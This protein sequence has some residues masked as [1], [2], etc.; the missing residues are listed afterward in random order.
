MQ[1]QLDITY[2]LRK[3]IFLDAISEKLFEPEEL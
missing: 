2:I 3:L 1:K